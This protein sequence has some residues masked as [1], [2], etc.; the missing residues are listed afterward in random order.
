MSSSDRPRAVVYTTAAPLTTE[1]MKY[2]A[3]G[4]QKTGQVDVQ[5]VDIEEYNQSGLVPDTDM[6]VILGIL[7]GTGHVYRDCM[8]RGIDFYYIDHAYFRPGYENGW[9]R[10]TKNHHITNDLRNANPDRFDTFFAEE[11]PIEPWGAAGDPDGPILVLP[12]T[13]AVAWM[14]H[15]RDWTER[16]CD[17]LAR[18]T[19][20]EVI[21]RRKPTE[22]RVTDDGELIGIVENEPAVGSLTDDLKRARC[23][24]IYNSN[25]V[26]E[27]LRIGVP[28]IAS[29]Y[30]AGHAV[31]RDLDRVESDE[32]LFAEPPR[33]DLFNW[34]A[35]CQF[36]LSELAN[37]G[38]WQTLLARQEG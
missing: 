18:L 19:D 10:V 36:H 22:P 3:D 37:G 23:A 27:A 6:F 38:G 1:I 20:R 21:V 11:Y 9:L 31:S 4:L 29:P 17:H 15:D 32:H 34:L 28:V 14:F 2:V 8:A 16:T 35:Q 24:V 30:C 7:R 13:D 26:I 33:R 25:S 12:P 5:F